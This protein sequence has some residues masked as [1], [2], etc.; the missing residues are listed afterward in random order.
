MSRSETTVQVG[1]KIISSNGK[2]TKATAS[3]QPFATTD[4]T[5]KHSVHLVHEVEHIQQKDY[6][7]HND[8]RE[9][10]R[11]EIL[12]YEL[13]LFEGIVLKARGYCCNRVARQ[14]ARDRVIAVA[15][16]E[17]RDSERGKTKLPSVNTNHL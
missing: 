2:Q 6:L 3:K 10:G 11:R 16:T 9:T 15:A 14:G 5:Q 7:F 13:R 17:L 4:A 12:R 1:V 8:Q